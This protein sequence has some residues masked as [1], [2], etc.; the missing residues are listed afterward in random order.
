MAD[1]RISDL[2]EATTL[3]GTELAL[4]SQGA[5]DR[6]ATL[7][8]LRDFDWV[9]PADWPAMLTTAANTVHLLAAVFDHTSNFAALR[10][11]ESS[12]TYSVDWGDGTSDSGITSATDATHTT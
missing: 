9:Q 7:Q 5:A 10:V 12:G 4:L 6:K 1:T 11:T 8:S 3:D 2:P